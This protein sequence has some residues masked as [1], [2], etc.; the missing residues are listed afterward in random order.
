MLRQRHQVFAQINCAVRTT[1]DAFNDG[2][3]T[4]WAIADFKACVAEV[5]LDG[6]VRAT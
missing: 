5:S 4:F 6:P 1:I 3:D 2:V